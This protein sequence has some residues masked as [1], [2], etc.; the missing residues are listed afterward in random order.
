M[1]SKEAIEKIERL[2]RNADDLRAI[3]GSP[4]FISLHVNPETHATTE[5]IADV[6][7]S[8]RRFASLGDMLAYGLPRHVGLKAAV[9][10]VSES[11]LVLSTVEATLLSK[12]FRPV[13]HVMALPKT[14]AFSLVKGWVDGMAY[15]PRGLVD[16]L[17]TTL[18]G[19][20]P[21]TLVEKFR[22][23][24][25]SVKVGNDETIQ[26]ANKT[27]DR[28]VARSVMADN[29]EALPTEIEVFIPVFDLPGHRDRIGGPN[30]TGYK[31]RVL[32]DADATAEGGAV[33]TLTAV[34]RDVRDAV[35]A[36]LGHIVNPNAE[37]HKDDLLIVQVP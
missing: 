7:P 31:I 25:A 12:T 21:S 9:L 27:I 2:A 36:A 24:K 37:A 18:D 14:K 28:N 20:L 5:V 10:A 30:S 1:L 13:D 23:I 8:G 33:I 15:D 17:R 11:S 35:E 6:A 16:E 3:P 19:C 26:V 22:R 4:G 32:V 34:E 29:N